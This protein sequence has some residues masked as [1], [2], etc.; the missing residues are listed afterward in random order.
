MRLS[1]AF[2]TLVTSLVLIGCAPETAVPAVDIAADEQAIRA[3][4]AE[5]LELAR[6]QDA[7]GIAALFAQD[8]RLIW[9][10]Q[11]PVVG[12]TAIQEFIANDFVANPTQTFDWS[13]DRVEVAASG[14]L[15]V[16]YGTYLNENRGPDGAEEER[17]SYVTVYRKVG[18][19]WQVAADASA[20]VTP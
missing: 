16:E 2:L 11:D 19:N 14:D 6:Q 5:W 9:G 18:G 1:A 3:I 20:S 10:G 7:A 12:P 15:G 13:A 8:G 4:S 17:G